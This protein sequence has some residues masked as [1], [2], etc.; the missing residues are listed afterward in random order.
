MYTL[1]YAPGTCSLAPHITLREADLP[2]EMKKVSTKTKEMEDGGDYRTVNPL[3]YVPTLGLPDGSLMTEAPVIL[4]YVADQAPDKALVPAQG[5]RERYTVHPVSVAELIDTTL[6]GSAELIQ[7]AQFTVERDVDPTLPPVMGDTLALTQCLQNLVTNALKYG[8]D[9]R[10]IGIQATL[11]DADDGHGK[12]VR[13]SVSDRGLGISA[14]DLPR[15]F[16]PFRSGHRPRARA[17]GLG[18]GLY[19]V[20]QLVIAHGGTVEVESTESAGTTFRVELP[21]R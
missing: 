2:F 15:I 9:R 6:A 16:D 12:E 18:L 1:Y 10:W 11:V 20:Q 14:G 13:I 5:T 4:Q 17:E 7:A 3:G 21:R 19:I 8:G